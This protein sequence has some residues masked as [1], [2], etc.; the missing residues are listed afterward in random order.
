M[1]R[2]TILLPFIF[3]LLAGC[4]GDKKAIELVQNTSAINANPMALAF[5]GK[6]TESMTW[7]ALMEMRVK[8]RDESLSEYKWEADRDRD[9]LRKDEWFVSFT[10]TNGYGHFF[11]ADITSN[12]V[13]HVNEDLLVSDRIGF[14]GETYD[15]SLFVEINSH[16]FEKCSEYGKHGFCYFVKGHATNKKD[17]IVKVDGEV[18]I[19]LKIGDKIIK[20]ESVNQEPDPFRTTSQ[21]KPWKAGEKRSFKYRSEMIPALYKD[22]SVKG[23][24]I[25]LF[26]ISTETIIRSAINE[27]YL[28]QRFNWP[29]T[30]SK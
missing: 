25:A 13:Y 11:V 21:N 30:L 24:G 2:L 28:I 22:V 27:H 16:G 3:M 1:R 6:N 26:D 12:Q 15:P 19:A 29:E 4:N 17:A 8:M 20:T 23:E 7:K 10:D 18:S 9:G 5:F 14:L